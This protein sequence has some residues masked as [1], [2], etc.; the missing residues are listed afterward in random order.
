MRAR[1]IENEW[2]LLEELRQANSGRLRLGRNHDHFALEVDGLPALL[3]PSSGF[4]AVSNMVKSSHSLRAVFPRYYPS[5]PVE[6]YLDAS[7]FHPNVQPDTGYV[8]LWTKHRVQTTLEQTLAQLQ[9]VLSWNL[10]NAETEHV[11]QPDALTW[12]AQDAAR[13]QLPLEF[14]PFVPV[15]S[16]AWI[17]NPTPLRRRLS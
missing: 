3:G 4:A 9:R 12:Y 16:E 1:R 10:F 6:I 5:M 14:T 2:L 7:V 11:M 8:C 13:A 17:P 15:H